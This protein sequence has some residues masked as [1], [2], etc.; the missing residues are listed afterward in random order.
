MT[1]ATVHGIVVNGV[2]GELVRVEV[3]VSDGLP[4]I[5]IV[6]LPDASLRK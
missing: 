2:R 5:G 4:S 1:L 3:A 6:G